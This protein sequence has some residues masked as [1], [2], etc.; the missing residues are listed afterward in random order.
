M[1]RTSGTTHFMRMKTMTAKPISWPMNVDI[2]WLPPGFT[3]TPR[4]LLASVADRPSTD[5]YSSVCVAAPCW[6]SRLFGV[7]HGFGDLAACLGTLLVD[8]LAG[9]PSEPRR[10]WPTLHRAHRPSSRRSR[11]ERRRVARPTCG[12]RPSSS[13]AWLPARQAPCRPEAPPISRSRASVIRKMSSTAKKVPL[14]TRKLLCPPPSSAARIVVVSSVMLSDY[15]A[16]GVAK[17][18]SAMKARLMK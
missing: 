8:D 12:C 5:E 13:P 17:T 9:R 4:I 18:N 3:S 7:S 15:D 14:G 2:Y 6:D 16:P 10:G 1:S 11:P